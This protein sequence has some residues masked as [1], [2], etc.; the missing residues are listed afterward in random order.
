MKL[1]QRIHE[2]RAE[3]PD[4]WTMDDFARDA[5]LLESIVVALT[6]ANSNWAMTVNDYNEIAINRALEKINA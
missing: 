1:S 6:S 4:E 5:A 2:W 3:R